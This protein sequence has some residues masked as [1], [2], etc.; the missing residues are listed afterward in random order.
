MTDPL[1]DAAERLIVSMPDG[2]SPAGIRHRAA[3][4]RHR[5][6]ISRI[7]AAVVLTTGSL[8]AVHLLQRTPRVVVPAESAPPPPPPPPP[9]SMSI[10][11]TMTLAPAPTS[12]PG[13]TATAATTTTSTTTTATT[14][15]A[16]TVPNGSPIAVA[17]LVS[18]VDGM[19]ASISV[20]ANDVDPD[21]DRLHLVS[22]AGVSSGLAIIDGD[23]L[24][25]TA[26]LGV[27]GTVTVA[28]TVADEMN[29]TSSATL[30]V[31]IVCAPADTSPGGTS[32]TC[33]E[34]PMATSPTE[35]NSTTGA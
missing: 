33:S 31:L 32:S 17:D 6:N 14:T 9:P 4:R 21:G 23:H 26:A 5:R 20:M 19:S 22:V 1:H 3:Q 15:T 12:V 11:P 34:P 27:S 25:Y 10:A 8:T 16:T 30:T 35:P 18:M 7:A 29:A 28:Y 24:V 13:S 2:V